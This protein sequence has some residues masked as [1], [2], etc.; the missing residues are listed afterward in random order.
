MQTRIPVIAFTILALTGC[1]TDQKK[2]SDAQTRINELRSEVVTLRAQRDQL[3]QQL[4]EATK[5][6]PA[7]E[8]KIPKFE[9]APPILPGKKT[10]PDWKWTLDVNASNLAD[11][12]A[13]D[14]VTINGAYHKI[15]AGTV[16]IRNAPPTTLPTTKSASQK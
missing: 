10:P 15:G 8:L 11:P 5:A 1:A 14:N 2:L 6:E 7:S 16:T 9:F 12:S 3:R 13:T 4:A